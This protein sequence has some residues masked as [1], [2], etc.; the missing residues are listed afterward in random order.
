MLCRKSIV[1]TQATLSDAPNG[2]V[3]RRSGW[4]GSVYIGVVRFEKDR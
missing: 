2:R 4:V 3:T 1:K